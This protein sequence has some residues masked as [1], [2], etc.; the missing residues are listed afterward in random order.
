MRMHIYIC[1]VTCGH[2]VSVYESVVMLLVSMRVYIYMYIYGHVWSLL[3]LYM[4]VY[5]NIRG[6]EWSCC[7][8]V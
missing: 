6:H 1:V 4:P 2:A 3:L 5:V 8:C 7:W